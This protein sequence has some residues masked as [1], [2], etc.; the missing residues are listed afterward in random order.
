MKFGLVLST[1]T[2]RFSAVSY[3]GDLARSIG[4]A[5]ALGYDGI[6]LAVRDPALVDSKRLKK[7]ISS[8]GMEVPAIGTGQAFL[9][10][11]LS[12]TDPR[13][14]IRKKAVERIRAH[15]CFAAE[16]NAA[17]IIG[18]IR[19]RGRE[20]GGEERGLF[21]E[22]LAVCAG[23]A[24]RKG[25]KLFIEPLNRYE[26]RLINTIEEGG[27][28]VRKI[29]HDNLK[30][31]IDT[32]HMNIEEPSICG[33]IVKAK[34]FLGH[35]HFSDSN[36]RP[37]GCG[38]LGFLDVMD[39]LK[40]IGYNKYISMEMMPWPTPAEAARQSVEYIKGILTKGTTK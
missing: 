11:G 37:P 40:G 8:A 30:L 9:E 12:L 15:V 19:G 34:P 39:V 14:E 16:F 18:L 4:R 28:L 33:S 36:R 21:E 5:A 2:T 26:T 27:E 24:A 38:H 31:L 22:S 20:N 3:S 13:K 6:E 29:K 10:E 1:N 7:I 17:V 32:F 35:V 25:V 23:F